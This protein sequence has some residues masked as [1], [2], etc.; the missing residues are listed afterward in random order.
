M[1]LGAELRRPCGM[2]R[3]QN[4]QPTEPHFKPPPKQRGLTPNDIGE[5][6]NSRPELPRPLLPEERATLK[7]ILTHADFDGRD[8]LAAQARTAQVDS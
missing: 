4:S 3:Q 8:A 5:I 1:T 2:S 6:L 7:A